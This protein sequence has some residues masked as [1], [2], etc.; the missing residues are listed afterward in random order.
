MPMRTSF[1]HH[2]PYRFCK[3]IAGVTRSKRD[4]PPAHFSLKIQTYS[5]LPKTEVE[6]Y[7]SGVFE[8]GGHKW[9]V[10]IIYLWFCTFCTL[11]KT[12]SHTC[13]HM[14]QEVVSS[15]KRNRRRDWLH[16]PLLG[17]SGNRYLS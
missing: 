12:L 4:L 14:L 8:A 10:S 17:N 5:L 16:L 15:P 3:Y 6:K 11:H 1:L 7:D 13:N 2:S 9:W